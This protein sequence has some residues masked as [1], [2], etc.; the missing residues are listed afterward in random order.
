MPKPN[1]RLQL[2]TVSSLILIILSVYMVLI[3]APREIIMGD[4]QRIFY[5]HVSSGWIAALAFLV[6]L[7]TSIMF[8]STQNKSYDRV[9]M[10]SAEIG[11]I[12]TTMNIV[13]GS[14]WARPVWNTW[15]TWDPRLTT[16][17]IMWLLYIAYLFLHAGLESH[18]RRRHI[19]AVYGIVAFISVPLTFMAIRI[20]RTIHPVIIGS[21]DPDAEG[22]FDMTARKTVTL[23]FTVLTFTVLYFT[24]LWH[25]VRIQSLFEYMSKLQYQMHND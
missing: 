14:I 9:A 23:L 2:M 6:T 11:V 21:A 22:Q 8:L 18:D 13:S 1:M 20:W 12:F 7:I 3:Y 4:V 24:I 10:S 15:W 25:R 5:Y 17:T 19:T 16:A